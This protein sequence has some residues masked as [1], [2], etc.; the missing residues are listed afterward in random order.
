LSDP[1]QRFTGLYDQYYRRVLRYALQHADQ[2]CAEDVAS[3]TFLITWRRLA[4][5]PEQPLP[6]LL[7]VARN[8]LRQQFGQQSRQRRLSDRISALTTEADLLTWDAGEHAVE[9]AAALDAL[10]AL[11]GDDVETLTLV[12]WHGLSATEAAAVVGCSPHAFTV[13]LHRA[14][15]RLGDALRRADQAN[16]HAHAAPAADRIPQPSASIRRER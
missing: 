11:P 8:L 15:K 3:E 14:R 13:R 4:D 16:A 2:A 1:E 10:G 5:V 12:T 9:R 7:G 6:W